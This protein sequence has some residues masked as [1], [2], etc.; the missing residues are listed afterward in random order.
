METPPD[1]DHGTQASFDTRAPAAL[2]RH[3]RARRLL[4][5]YNDSA[6]T[7]ANLRRRMLE[8][9]L[10]SVG[11]GVWIEPPF[12]CDDG[13]NIALGAG[14]FLNFNCVFLDGAPITLGPGT[15]LG[16]AVQIYATTH[17]L[18]AED[19]MFD[20]DGIPAYRTTA[21]PVTI[22]AHVW[23]GGGAI[24]LPGVTIGDGAVIGAG[25]VVT[26]D[27]PPSSFA[28]GNPCRVLRP[29]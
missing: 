28:A 1:R 29:L 14:T 3:H 20:R 19:R 13:A 7:E 18:R 8:D 5:Q 27:V 10:G 25:A 15:L 26:G 4:R 2:A 11:E 9:L 12:H 16:P 6:S 23:I 22:G 17:P 24:V 21:E